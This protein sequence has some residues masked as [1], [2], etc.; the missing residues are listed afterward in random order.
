MLHSWLAARERHHYPFDPATLPLNGVYIV[1]EKGERGH[2]TDRIVRIGTHTGENQLRS[3]LFQHF[4]RENKDRSIFRKNIGRSLL[5]KARDSFAKAW[6]WDLTSRANREKYA[7]RVNKK[8]MLDTEKSVS[9]YIQKRFSFTA[10]DVPTKADRL[11][12][13][14]KLIATI[15]Q[16]PYCTASKS[17][18]GHHSPKQEIREYGLWQINELRSAPMTT[19]EVLKFIQKHSR[20]ARAVLK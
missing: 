3:R 15:A 4:V 12:L 9:A 7:R 10:L 8:K 16:C 13:E 11:A 17:W 2:D 18:L 19:Q 20:K 14:S 5:A 6:E 1:F